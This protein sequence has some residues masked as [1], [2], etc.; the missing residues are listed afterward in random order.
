MD[1]HFKMHM[2]WALYLP[3]AIV[4][5]A[6]SL[7]A[8]VLPVYAGQLTSAYIIIGIALSAEHIGRVFGD[9]PSAVLLRRFGMKQTMLYGLAVMVIAIGLLYFAPN[10][11]VVMALLVLSGIGLAFY[12]IARH[13]YI[14]V[15]FANENMGRAISLFGGVYRLGKFIGPLLGGAIGGFIGLRATF[16]AYALMTIVAAWMVWRFM[17]KAD[18]IKKTDAPEVHATFTQTIRTRG[19]MFMRAGLGQ[20][21]A[22]LTRTGWGVLI[23]LYAA[24]VLGLSVEMIGLVMGI[25]AIFDALFFYLSGIIMD[26]FGRKWAIVPSFAGQGLAIALMPLTTGAASLAAVSAL[27]G[28]ANAIGSGTMM[29]LGSDL[30]P[31]ESRGEFLSVWRL[32]GDLGFVAGPMIVGVV[33]QALVL[34]LSVMAIA[35]TGVGAALAF[36]LLVP[37]T[38]QKQQHSSKTSTIN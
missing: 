20:I 7:L 1:R 12:N 25:G 28:F 5:T 26:R 18:Y 9:L 37:E 38:L 10:I 33:A 32:I 4:A 17:R 27:I 15:M 13:A 19:N 8:P 11:W 30:A 35:G 16:P 24:N 31:R 21:L 22:Q 34:Q 36:G 14:S 6:A 3:S 23:P 29:T 2:L